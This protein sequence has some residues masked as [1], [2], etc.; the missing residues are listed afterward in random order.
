MASPPLGSEILSP[1]SGSNPAAEAGPTSSDR[2]PDHIRRFDAARNAFLASL[3]PQ[4]RSL[5]SPCASF[6]EL[7]KTVGELHLIKERKIVGTKIFEV[8]GKIHD[9]LEPYFKV[10]GI[11]VSSRPEWAALAWGA[12]RLVLQ[13]SLFH[14]PSA[15]IWRSR[16]DGREV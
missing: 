5:Y 11:F 13:V 10:V 6:D 16:R 2:V 14:D 12:I 15:S 7:S 1:A 3:S 9:T 4:D 8:L